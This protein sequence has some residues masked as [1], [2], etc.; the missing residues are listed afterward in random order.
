MER[1]PDYAVLNETDRHSICALA[2]I[3]SNRRCV[4]SQAYDKL[5]SRDAS[6]RVTASFSLVHIQLSSSTNCDRE[7]FAAEQ[8]GEMLEQAWTRNHLS[9]GVLL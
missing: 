4:G 9:A 2:A 8:K 1:H 7:I 6:L 3:L 5:G